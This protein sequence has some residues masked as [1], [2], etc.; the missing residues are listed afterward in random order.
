MN[1]LLHP[2]PTVCLGLLDSLGTPASIMSV[3][4]HGGFSLVAVNALAR[5]FYGL[6]APAGITPLTPDAV[7]ALTD[8]TR[9]ENLAYLARMLGHYQK[10]VETGNQVATESDYVTPTG[11]TRWSRNVVTPICDEGVL[12]RLLVTQVDITEIRR[13]Q[14]SLE[15]SLGSL[16]SGLVHY[17][18]SCQ[19]VQ[20][21]SGNW[22]GIASYMARAGERQFSHGICHSCVSTFG[23]EETS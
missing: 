10:V 19:K 17:C 22:L 6:K 21:S 13:M 15:A 1:L 5:Q 20:E 18:E 14:A 7:Q 23:M 16:V 2:D 8:T 12:K 4:A 9:P 11:E 3:E